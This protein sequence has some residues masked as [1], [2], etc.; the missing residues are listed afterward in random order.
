[1]TKPTANG[2]IEHITLK[3][4][5][6]TYCSAVQSTH[7]MALQWILGGLKADSHD[8]AALLRLWGRCKGRERPPLLRAAMAAACVCKIG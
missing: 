3:C 2:S 7:G 1:M 4:E 5:R 6:H 8:R